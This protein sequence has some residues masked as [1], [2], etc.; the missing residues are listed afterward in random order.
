M[1]RR[2]ASNSRR[3]SNGEPACL[4]MPTKLCSLFSKDAQGRWRHACMHMYSSRKKNTAAPSPQHGE[5]TPAKIVTAAS[6]T[7]YITPYCCPGFPS[8]LPTDTSIT[9]VDC[10]FSAAFVSRF[11]L[12][13]S[14]TP[15]RAL[16]YSGGTNTTFVPPASRCFPSSY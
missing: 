15:D 4:A 7:P 10:H 12:A 2:M 11:P 16:W 9:A 13:I 1:L 8:S 5:R 6:G 3:N 14:P